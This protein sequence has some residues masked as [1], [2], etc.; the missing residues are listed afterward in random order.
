MNR[1]R[2]TAQ[3]EEDREARHRRRHRPPRVR[4]DIKQRLAESFE[5]ALRWP[6]GVRSRWRWT[7]AAERE[8]LFNAKFAC[9]C[10]TTHQRAGAA[11]VLVQLAGGRLPTCDGLGTWSSSTPARGRLPDAEPGQ[12]RDQGLGPAQRL[13]LQP[14]GKPGAALRF[15]VDTAVRGPACRSQNAVLHGSGE[16]DIEF[17]YTRR[18]GQRPP[19]TVKRKHPFEGI[20]P[21]IERRYRETDSAAVREDLARYRGLQPCPT[22]AA[23]ACARSAARAS[24]GEGRAGGRVASRSSRSAT[25]HA[26]RGAGLLQALEAARRQGRD[27]RQGGARD[28]LA[29]EVPER[30]GLNYLSLDRSADTLSGGESQRIRLASQIG[31]GLTG[32]MYVL[33]EP[34]IGLHQRDNDR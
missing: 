29:A 3:A 14:A 20:I 5:A 10:A 7:G 13:L 26:A 17:S 22:A 19:R 25:R 8:H 12:R 21:N 28:P 2:R 33:D 6:T 27:R 16:E 11:A 32:V 23:R 30:R 34:S 15:D 18:L 24:S 4:P 31:S 9:P 1:R